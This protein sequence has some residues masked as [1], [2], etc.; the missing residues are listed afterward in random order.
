MKNLGEKKIV[1]MNPA[2]SCH[3]VIEMVIREIGLAKYPL[4][5]SPED[6]KIHPQPTRPRDPFVSPS[7]LILI[8]HVER[9]NEP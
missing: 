7:V 6:I 1:G 4:Q 5:N 9:S 3:L 8:H 2:F